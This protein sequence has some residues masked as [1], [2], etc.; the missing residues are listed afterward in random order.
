[1]VLSVPESNCSGTG[2]VRAAQGGSCCNSKGEGVPSHIPSTGTGVSDKIYTYHHPGRTM[3]CET[4]CVI[5]SM[6][7]QRGSVEEQVRLPDG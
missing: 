5:N 7:C 1:M 3:G 2:S 6:K 4:R